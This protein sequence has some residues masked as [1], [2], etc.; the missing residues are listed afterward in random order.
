MADIFLI[1]D[2]DLTKGS[3]MGG[4]I[5]I[6]KYRSVI[7]ETQ[8]FVIEPILGTKLYDKILADFDA[9]TL[10]GDYLEL[11]EEY[12]KP[13]IINHVAG[14]YITIAG[15]SVDNA[16]IFRRNPQDT[17][18][19][20]KEEID[21]LS[22]KQKAK[23][24]VYIERMQRYLC[25]KDIAEYTAPQDENYDQKPD[26]DLTTFGGLRLSSNRF[27]GTNAEREIWRDIFYDEGK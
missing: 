13:I 11:H 5:D 7:K 6:D 20:T 8:V 12:I 24:D 22:N 18:P 14:E 3:P 15:F 16:G 4:N 19:A 10:A 9:D 26:H 21:F 17:Q 23:A 1:T 25:D 27:S 2:V